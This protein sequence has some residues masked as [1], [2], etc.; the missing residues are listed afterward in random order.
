MGALP[1]WFDRL[2]MK[3]FGVAEGGIKAAGEASI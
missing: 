1:S 2:T 3:A